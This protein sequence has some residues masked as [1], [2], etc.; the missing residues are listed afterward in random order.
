MTFGERI[1]ELRKEKNLTMKQLSRK[2]GVTAVTLSNWK[3]GKTIPQKVAIKKV[4]DALECDFKELLEY[5]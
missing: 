4:A 3:T 1:D 5:L 2:S